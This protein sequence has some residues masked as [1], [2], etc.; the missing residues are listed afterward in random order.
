MSGLARSLPGVATVGGPALVAAMGRPG[1]F[2][3]AAAFRSSLLRTT[4]I[5]AA[6]NSRRPDLQLARIY[7]AQMVQ[8]GADDLN[9][10]TST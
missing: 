2:P 7:Y 3:T 5:R 4:L 8:R 10:A 6:D 1:R 9:L